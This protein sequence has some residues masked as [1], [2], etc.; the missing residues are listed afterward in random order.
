MFA[1]F[2]SLF[3][4]KGNARARLFSKTRSKSDDPFVFI[5]D[6]FVDGGYNKV[7]KIINLVCIVFHTFSFCFLEMNYFFHHF[8]TDLLIK[9]GFVIA[10]VLYV[11]TIFPIVNF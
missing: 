11:S 10:I 9:Y 5:K 1:K 7:A 6:I 4:S 2:S 8:T 3:G